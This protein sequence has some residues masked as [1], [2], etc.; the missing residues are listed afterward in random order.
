MACRIFLLTAMCC[1]PAIALSG[2]AEPPAQK[3]AARHRLEFE[4]RKIGAPRTYTVD[5]FHSSSG[6]LFYSTAD[7]KSLAVAE[8]DVLAEPK[9][10]VRPKWVR[11][12]YVRSRPWGEEAF[13]KGTPRILVETFTD[14]ATGL[15]VYVS[16]SGSLAAVPHPDK[17]KEARPMPL[18]SLYRLQ[19]KVR[20]A[21]END[22]TRNPLKV[23]VEV[24]LHEPTGHLVYLADNGAIAVVETK[25]DFANLEMPKP[26]KWSHAL[27]LKARKPKE[28]GFDKDTPR[29]GVEVYHDENADV[30]LYATDA[31]TLAA[32]PAVAMGV[33]EKVQQPVWKYQLASGDF[34]A[35]VFDNP[36]AGHSLAVTHSGGLA[37]WRGDVKK[38]A[39]PGGK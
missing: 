9:G 29:I 38:P 19:L 22:F 17:P 16:E 23:S 18:S 24:C 4:I 32:A 26:A 31:L 8:C 3:L 5:A 34:A 35:E 10:P 20:P 30:L 39:P 28:A 27:E 12:S 6:R 14:L 37:A 7:G 2:G 15:V 1:L 33:P 21:G 13:G 25:N 36:N 11:A